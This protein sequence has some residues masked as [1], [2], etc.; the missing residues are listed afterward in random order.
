MLEFTFQESEESEGSH[1]FLGTKYSEIQRDRL[2][3]RGS[4]RETMEAPID[5]EVVVDMFNQTA[6]HA[7]PRRN[8]SGD[9]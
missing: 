4:S 2:T 8:G 3:A 5:V 6:L 9:S 7:V 1:P